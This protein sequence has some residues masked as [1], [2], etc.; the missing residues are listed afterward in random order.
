MFNVLSIMDSCLFFD[1]TTTIVMAWT[2]AV[3]ATLES[4]LLTPC[5]GVAQQVREMKFRSYT[6]TRFQF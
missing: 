6:S 4:F 2:S 3:S 5:P 1:S